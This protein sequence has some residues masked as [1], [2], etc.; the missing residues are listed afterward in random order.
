MDKSDTTEKGY[1][2]VYVTTYGEALPVDGALVTILKANG[3]KLTLYKTALTDISGHTQI[4]EFETPLKELSQTP[5]EAE[6]KTYAKYIVET[7]MDGYIP[8]VKY[9]TPVYSGVVTTLPVHLIP[10]GVGQPE[11]FIFP[12]EEKA[13]L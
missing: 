2:K 5:Q 8:V 3:E 10:K 4:F 7:T 13:D 11:V 9:S 1:L 12:E 6:E